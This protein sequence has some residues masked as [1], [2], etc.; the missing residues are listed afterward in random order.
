MR[1][2]SSRPLAVISASGQWFDAGVTLR[3]AARSSEFPDFRIDEEAAFEP[4][5]L[6]FP[7][8]EHAHPI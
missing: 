4:S 2:K 3:G 8:L 1:L 5:D 7:G 6:P